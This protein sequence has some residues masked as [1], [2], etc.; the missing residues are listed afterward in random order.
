MAEKNTILITGS[1]GQVSR[2]IQQELAYHPNLDIVLASRNPDSNQHPTF[3]TVYMD[4]NDR[5]SIRVALENIDTVFMMTGYSIDMLQQSKNFVDVAQK[6]QLSHIVHLGACG[7]DDTEVAHWGWHQFIEKYIAASGIGFTHLRPEA[8]MQNILG[9]QGDNNL[10]QGV[11]KSYFGNAR[12]SWVDCQDVAKMAI[13]CLVQPS[14]HHGKTYRLGHD[15]KT[16]AEIAQ[17]ITEETGKKYRYEAE[18]PD[19]F[20]KNA[21]QNQLELT[22]MKS[23][24]D[25]YIAHAQLKIPNADETFNHFSEVTS[26][27]ATDIRQFIRRHLAY[28]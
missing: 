5:E 22:Y 8:F 11:L 10:E 9:Y 14:L 28:F 25:H 18:H 7:G 17:I 20:W 1:T 12:L 15:A 27:Q 21:L 13:H 26:E 16:Y 23:I 3:P 24:Y 2:L 19:I 4:Y 6:S